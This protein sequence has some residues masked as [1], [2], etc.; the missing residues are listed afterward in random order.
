MF[1]LRIE[2]PSLTTSVLVAAVVAVPLP[3]TDVISGDAL[4]ALTGG[5]IGPAGPRGAGG[6]HWL[7]AGAGGGGSR[8]DDWRNR[9]PC[10]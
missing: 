7:P 10:F 9:L 1:F 4:S 8:G 3:V 2:T 5:L 6:P